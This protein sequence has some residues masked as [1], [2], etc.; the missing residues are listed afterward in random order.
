MRLDLHVHSR[1]SFDGAMPVETILLLAIRRGLHGVAITDHNTSRGA[2]EALGAVERLGLPLV[3]IP[4][5]EYTTDE[6]HI[7]GLFLEGPLP[8]E[9]ALSPTGRLPWQR[10][11]EDIRARGGISILAHPFQRR[12]ILSP[13]LL[14]AVDGVEVFNARLAYAP[15]PHA[16]DDA[17]EAALQKGG[18]W[19]GGSDAHTPSEVGR[20]WVELPLS[21]Q[22]GLSAIRQALRGPLRVGGRGSPPWVE[23]VSQA[24][25]L[26]ALKEGK[27]L[28]R[29]LLKGAWNVARTCLYPRV[30]AR[31]RVMERSSP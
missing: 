24:R 30:W 8:L 18:F 29:F 28:P 1:H 31:V 19:T 4:G 14:E 21:P 22:A 27:R 2:W 25:R 13:A 6:G 7:L 20:G 9:A 17:W 26:M 15:N 23:T 3:V 12:R 16:L 11:V 10:V 5:G